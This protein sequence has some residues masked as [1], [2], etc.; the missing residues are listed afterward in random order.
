MPRTF[1][2]IEIRHEGLHKYRQIRGTDRNVV[3]Q[4]AQA[5]LEAWEEIWRKKLKDEELRSERAKAALTKEH[6]KSLAIT[7]TK[8][9]KKALSDIENTL[10]VVIAEDCKI[11]WEKIKDSSEFNKPKPTEPKMKEIPSEPSETDYKYQP[12]LSFL[13]KIFKNS[14][15]KKIDK[16]LA[17]FKEEHDE[18]EKIKKNLLSEFK[19]ETKKYEVNLI[20][21]ESDK[22]K[23]YD[24]QK[25]KNDAIE[26]QKEAYFNKDR[27]AI[28]DYCHMVLSKSSYP[29]SFPQE[30]E[31]DYRPDTKII[32]I[33][34]LL[35]HIDNI[36]K[37][38]EVN[39]NQSRNEFK[40]TYLS[41]SVLN[42]MYDTFLYNMTLRS[43]YEVFN[44]DVINSIDSIVF[45][46]FVKAI[47]K[48]VGKEVTNC[49]LSIQANKDEFINFNLREVDPKACFKKLKGVSASKLYGLS[50][51]P[52]IL[53]IDREDARFISAYG[54][55]DSLDESVNIAAMDWQDFEQLIRELFEKE[56]NESGGEVKI[57]Q[58]SRDGGVDA[59][60]FDP[61]PI[62]G[63]KIVIQAKRYT[64]VVGV[65]FVRDL[66]GTVI[67]EGASRGILVTTAE[68]GPDAYDFAKDKPITLLN[69]SNL[70]HLLY[71]HGHKAKID[72]KEA[73]KILGEEVKN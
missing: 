36:P 41:E 12:K 43:L 51:I 52:P 14:K 5:Q 48:S 33:D 22:N 15:Q 32:I 61:D 39:Y 4:T 30:Y 38:K 18:W 16:C 8:E 63:G 34:Y 60:A 45:N 56:F 10:L 37:L 49:I 68:Y 55:A 54:V 64:N 46:G 66:Y 3:E 44:A 23:Y 47:D 9:A 19:N 7:Q 40:E 57:T 35:P 69:G 24:L 58:A 1:Y 67:N 13:D 53:Q 42:K 11:D 27:D 17:W 70:L 21:W 59:I 31:I 65:A 2:Q 20:N 72:L 62:R 25:I 6:K 29:E 26:K 71:K 73:K 50:A 28:I